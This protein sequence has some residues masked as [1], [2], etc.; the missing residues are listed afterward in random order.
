MSL[1][2]SAVVAS[3]LAAPVQDVRSLAQS[4]FRDAT[5]TA[6]VADANQRELQKINKDF[7]N[8]Y[9]FKSSKVWMKEPL[10]LR[11]ESVVDDTQI[12]FIVNGSK[13]LVRVPRAGISQRENLAKAPGKRQT[14]LDFGLLTP[15]L[16][17][18][19][20]TG[21]FVREEARGDFAGDMV[22]DLTYV[23]SLDDTTRHRVWIDPKMRFTTKR[24]WYSQNGGFLVA[25]FTYSEPKQVGGVWMP[26]RVTVRNADGKVAGSSVYKDL[27][28]NTGLADTLFKVD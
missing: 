12:F 16:F 6:Q 21:K 3:T 23:P 8:S 9:R 13:R 14:P 17:V 11:M 7:A 1:L 26:T 20:F 22:F 4:G 15:S 10:M 24:E 18:N 2:L 5:F 19:F 28:V 25:T 27:K